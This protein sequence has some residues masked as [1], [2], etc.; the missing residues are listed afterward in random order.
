MTAC[1]AYAS[2]LVHADAHV[3]LFRV[4]PLVAA[5]F[6]GP[7]G[8]GVQDAL[9]AFLASDSEAKPGAEAL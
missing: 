1:L 5:L 4:L 9:R 3:L 7:F 6:G 8:A 2:A